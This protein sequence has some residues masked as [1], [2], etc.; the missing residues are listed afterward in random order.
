MPS[1]DDALTELQLEPIH[2]PLRA[3]FDGDLVRAVLAARTGRPISTASRPGS[4]RS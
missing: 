2:V 4:P 3:I 1:L